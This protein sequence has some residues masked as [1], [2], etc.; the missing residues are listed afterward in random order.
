MGI[1]VL[2]IVLAVT[3][4][5]VSLAVAAAFGLVNVNDPPPQQ[6]NVPLIT[7]GVSS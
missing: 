5:G 6:R 4:A 1:Q 7:Y 3:V 2:W